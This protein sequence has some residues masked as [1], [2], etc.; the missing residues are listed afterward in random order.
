MKKIY[1]H[2]GPGKT[3]SSAIQAWL[4]E[5]RDFLAKNG[6]Y[7]PKHDLDAT[8]ISSGN[9]KS[10]LSHYNKKWSVDKNKVKAILDNFHSSS[11][12][13]LLL[14]SEHFFAELEELSEVF[15]TATFIFYLRHPISTIESN[16]NQGVK[17]H[18]FTHKFS[19]EASSVFQIKHLT[20]LISMIGV[21]RLY[22]KGYESALL[23]DGGIV[24]DFL[25]TFDINTKID[26]KTVNPSYC[27]EALEFK[28]LLNHFEISEYQAAIDKVLQSYNSGVK[29]Y[30]LIPL[31]TFQAMKKVT[32][33]HLEQLINDFSLVHLTSLIEPY[34]NLQQKKFYDQC[35]TID[36]INNIWAYIK[37]KD[38]RLYSSL[39]KTIESQPFYKLDN[40]NFYGATLVTPKPICVTLKDN[41]PLLH[42]PLNDEQKSLVLNWLGE[43]YEAQ[44]N[45][46]NALLFFEAALAQ[47]KTD[48]RLYN[49]YAKLQVISKI[50]RR[51]YMTFLSS[52]INRLRQVLK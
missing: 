9:L 39:K 20:D 43:Y 51:P 41:E 35:V 33:L 2:V 27:L 21:E 10:V 14:S 23:K 24:A 13:V 15:P 36:E 38:R 6:I 8:G 44:E 50:K 47:N 7:Y 11:Y 17:R 19:A 12:E 37:S 52:L 46:E 25:Q 40:P 45:H 26:N 16:Y 1:I 3:G 42:I 5:N 4:N 28:R 31:E 32:S 22:I 29:N 49:K 18:F 34:C 30:S 48:H